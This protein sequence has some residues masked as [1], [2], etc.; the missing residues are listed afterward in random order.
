MQKQMEEVQ[1]EL[2]TTVIEESSGGGAVVVTISAQ[3]SI[4]GLKIDPEFLKEE[5]DVVSETLLEAVKGAQ[6]K[7]KAVSEERMG[8]VTS[9]LSLP[10]LM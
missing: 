10:G 4:L 3:G 7:A 6:A 8:S 2:A 5:A 9:G 1:Q